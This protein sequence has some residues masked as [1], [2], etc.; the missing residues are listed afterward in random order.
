MDVSKN[1]VLKENYTFFVGDEN[2]QIT[3]SSTERGLFNRD[4]RFLKRYEWTMDKPLQT[5]VTHYPLPDRFEAH[6][7]HI[8]GP[9][10][11]VGIKRTLELMPLF[12]RDVLLVENTSLEKQEVRLE[13]HYGSD[14]GDLFEARGWQKVE[15]SNISVQTS[16]DRAKLSY[17]AEDNLEFG[18][19]LK[20]L[21]HASEVTATRAIFKLTLQPGESYT[22]AVDVEIH[23]P[24]EPNLPVLYT[25]SEWRN[26]ID[27]SLN[28][29]HHQRVL[30]RA[31]EDLRAL[32]LFTEHGP[33]PAAGIPWYVTA[34]G[35]DSLLTAHMMLPY[36]PEVAKGTLRYLGSKQGKKHDG[37]HAESPGK[38]LHE[39]RYGELSRTN[40]VPFTTYYGTVDATVLYI[41]LLHHLYKTTNDLDIVKE[42]RLNWEA[43]LSWMQ[44]DGDLD[45]DG[46]IEF[47][48]AE[49]G[50]GHAVQSWKDSHD[51][52][53]YKDG[54]LAQGN[55]AVSEVQGYAYAAYLGVVEFYDVLGDKQKAGHYREKAEKLKKKFHETFWIEDM[56]TYALALDGDKKRLEVHNSDAGH[57]LWTGIVPEE[58]APKL[59]QT[60]MS[61]AMWTGWGIRTLGKNEVRY[62]PVSYHNGSVW[63]HDTAL[64]AIGMM[65]YGFVEEAKKIREATFDLAASQTDARLP[66][67]V[68]GYTRSSSPPVPYPVACRPQAWDAAALLYLLQV[69]DKS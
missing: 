61:E 42:L 51:S 68:A 69:E 21:Q 53:S 41:L 45:K 36:C 2:G 47:S 66:E 11:V 37:Y 34:F 48:P 65:N 50:K 44:N 54:G 32:L 7:A 20:F 60:L 19:T 28:N 12:L 63:P 38:I 49:P 3:T 15:R 6:Y 26:Q 1:T 56:Q 40:K 55:I 4:T 33:L 29:Q 8:D 67:L 30:N 10:Q 5:L 46:F 64:A 23:N 13:L 31:V 57:L 43:A 27:V 58:I 14:F 16:V 59:V 39:V 52:L 24:L 17:V 22:L 25:Y 18:V 35:R 62:N 9:S